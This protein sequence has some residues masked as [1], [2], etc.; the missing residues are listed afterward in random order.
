MRTLLCAIAMFAEVGCDGGGVAQPELSGPRTCTLAGCVAG[1]S[2]EATMQQ[3]VVEPTRL[4]VRACVNGQCET[5]SPAPS[6]PGNDL[7]YDCGETHRLHCNFNLTRDRTKMGVRIGV[8]P[9]P[10]S[11]SLQSLQDGDRYEITVGVPGE[12]PILSI[13]ATATY[14]IT[15]PNGPGCSPTCKY[16]FLKADQ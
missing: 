3:P 1:A 10:G 2:Y 14:S 11:D 9:P 8:E 12:A 6:I 16:F 7:Y 4:V 13:N 15:Q 5:V